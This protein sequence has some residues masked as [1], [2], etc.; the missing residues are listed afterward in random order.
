MWTAAANH[1]NRPATRRRDNMRKLT[2]SQNLRLLVDLEDIERRDAAAL[3]AEREASKKAEQ[4][5]FNA[6]PQDMEEWD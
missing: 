1:Q 2:P 5:R 6:E 3:R 4:L